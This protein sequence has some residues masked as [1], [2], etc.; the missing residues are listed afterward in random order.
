MVGSKLR[1]PKN[2][3]NFEKSKS[4]KEANFGKTGAWSKYHQQP[5]KPGDRS[6]QKVANF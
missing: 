2:Q 3:A 6:A 4:G 5:K 1:E